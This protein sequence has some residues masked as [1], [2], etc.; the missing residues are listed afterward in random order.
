VK[1]KA[2]LD[3]TDLKGA[4]GRFK[5]SATTH[6]LVDPA[7]AVMGIVEDGKWIRYASRKKK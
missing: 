4:T 6:E 5:F 1:L 7:D 3:Q 2:A